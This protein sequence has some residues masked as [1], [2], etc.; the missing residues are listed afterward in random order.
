MLKKQ[1][2]ERRGS[3]ATTG[4]GARGEIR[5]ILMVKPNYEVGL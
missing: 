5:M 2:S 1:Q 4:R 3:H